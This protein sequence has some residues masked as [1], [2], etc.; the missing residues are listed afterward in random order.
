MPSS[1]KEFYLTFIKKEQVAKDAYAFYFSAKGGPGS[2]WDFLPGQYIH[3]Y[4]PVTN[5]DGR[6]DSRMLTI[7]SSPFEKQYMVFITRIIQSAFKKTLLNLSFQTKVKFYGPSGGFVLNENETREQVFL[8]GGIGITPFFSML[9][10]IDKKKLTLKA[11]LM[12]SF[13]TVEDIIYKKELEDLERRNPNIKIIY[14]ITHPEESR[15]KDDRPLAENW[16]GEKGRISKELIAKYVNKPLDSLYYIVGPPNMVDAM[17]DI[18]SE[19]G[20]ASKDILT[21]NFVGY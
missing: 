4:L 11:T 3:M 21:E 5:D 18:V 8:A 13:S 9:S 17:H 14:T 12:V 2:A 6:G 7:A 15:P 10:Y 1:A 19:M 16:D 20:V